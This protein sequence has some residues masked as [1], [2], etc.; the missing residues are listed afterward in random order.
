MPVFLCDDSATVQEAIV[1]ELD[2]PENNI[3][4]RIS[5]L[6]TLEK[7]LESEKAAAVSPGFLKMDLP[8]CKTDTAASL[9]F[10][11]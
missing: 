7:L 9:L 4:G 2:I 1:K 5:N 10:V 8:V 3:M 6:K 11:S